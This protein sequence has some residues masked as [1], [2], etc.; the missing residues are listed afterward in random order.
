MRR[1]AAAAALLAL[2]AGPACGGAAVTPGVAAAGVP[3]SATVRT[4]EGLLGA[5]SSEL[6]DPTNPSIIIER[7]EALC[8]G[9]RYTPAGRLLALDVWVDVAGQCPGAEPAYGVEGA[10][11]K[12]VTFRSTRADVKQAFGY[13]PDRVL[14]ADRFTVL[15]YD[16]E[17][18]AFYVREV[19]ERR[20]LVDTITV[21]RRHAS[22]TV[23][24]PR[25]WGG[26]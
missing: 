2:A 12:T 25:S 10:G 15:V 22:R 18:V 7:W 5:P 17:G 16:D 6:Q 21:F 13:R 1:A 14:R 8:L 11:G 26:Q 4:V 24:A 20:G 23:W 19:G 3:L 9:A